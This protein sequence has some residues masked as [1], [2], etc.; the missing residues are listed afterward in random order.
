MTTDLNYQKTGTGEPIVFIHGFSLDY[1][2]WLPQIKRFSPA[3]LV[4]TYDLRGFGK[5][6]LPVGPY[7]HADDLHNLLENLNI[8]K[9]HLVGLSLGGEIAVDYTLS[10]PEKVISLTL[11][12]SSL[13][14]Y[15]STVDWQVY[16]KEK[17][18][19][20]GRQN[21]LN[22][23]VFSSTQSKPKVFSQLQQIVNDYSG[24]HW[25]NPDP[26]TKLNPPATDRLN[27]IIVPT[28][29]IVGELDLPYYHNIADK[30][31]EKITNSQLDI[32]GNSGHM[33]N[34]EKAI[35]FNSILANHLK[36]TGRTHG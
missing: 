24:W 27:N 29:V 17:G 2:M 36:K 35:S 10:H 13:G 4:I 18:V 11:A 28:E 9:T 34:L 30:L 32:L 19:E 23:S 12:G 15:P 14:G 5:S 3:N 8:S 25:L 20:K 31:I 1:R 22:H 21:W 16:A 6:P 7:S 26:R 33:V